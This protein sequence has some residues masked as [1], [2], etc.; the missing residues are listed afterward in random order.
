ML[1]TQIIVGP[2]LQNALNKLI[3]GGGDSLTLIEAATKDSA[4]NV[5]NEAK[6]TCPIATGALRDS[7]KVDFEDNGLTAIIGSQ[8]P[9]AGVMEYSEVPHP[10]IGKGVKYQSPRSGR[11]YT[12]SRR[13]K[14][15]SNPEATWGFLRKALYKETPEFIKRL[16]EI[17]K[18]FQ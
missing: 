16:R 1:S 15:N 4:I 2:G 11:W 8:L 13:I 12:S 14:M 5:Q 9:Y 3:K 18:V 6:R 7:I 10:V 17:V